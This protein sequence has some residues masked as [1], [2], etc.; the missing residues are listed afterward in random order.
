MIFLKKSFYFVVAWHD[1]K[2]YT[3][4]LRALDI[5]YVIETPEEIPSLQEGELAFVFP[6]L[7][8]RIYVKVRMLF[9]TTGEP[10]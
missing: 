3:D 4:A 8:I 7:P 10:Y 6:N 5:P 1:A 9:G 2:K